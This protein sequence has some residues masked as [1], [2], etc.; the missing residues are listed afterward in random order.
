M[1]RQ[2]RSW[3]QRLEIHGVDPSG[4][5]FWVSHPPFRSVGDALATLRALEDKARTKPWNRVYWISDPENPEHG[6]VLGQLEDIEE[7][8]E[9]DPT[10]SDCEDDL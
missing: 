7:G 1:S 4:T 6:S 3:I 9:F 2:E 8:L 10:D 5:T